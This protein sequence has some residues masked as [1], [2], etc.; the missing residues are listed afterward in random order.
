MHFKVQPSTSF[1]RE[2]A[3]HD[4]HINIF[5]TGDEECDCGSLAECEK[6]G[7]MKCCQGCKLTNQC[8]AGNYCTANC[9][10]KE[11][12]ECEKGPCCHEGKLLKGNVF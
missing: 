3:L 2:R 5:V 4:I 11:G 9:T 12:Y 10:F 1:S 6:N 8:S 7:Q